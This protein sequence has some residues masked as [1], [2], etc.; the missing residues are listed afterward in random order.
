MLPSVDHQGS[1]FLGKTRTFPSVEELIAYYKRNSLSHH[2]PSI[3]STLAIPMGTR[4]AAFFGTK[5]SLTVIFC[6]F[7]DFFLYC[8][9]PPV[10]Q[11]S[12]S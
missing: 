1:Y 7:F 3:T 11:M 6:S 9:C 12:S 10:F 4:G 8:V 5:N 2:F